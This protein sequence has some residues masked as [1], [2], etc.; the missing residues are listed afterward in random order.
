[1]HPLIPFL[2]LGLT[3]TPALAKTPSV[4]VLGDS[5]SAGYGLKR[6]QAYPALLSEKA[7]GMGSNLIVMNAGVSGDTT[8]GGLRRLPRLLQH[9][10]DVLVIELGINDAFRGVPIPQIEANLQSII[11]LSKKRY[12]QVRI[13][14][15]GMQLPISGDDDYLDRFGAIFPKLAARNHAALIPF[16]LAGVAGNRALNQNDMIHPNAS[17][18]KILAANVWPVLEQVL[19]PSS[20]SGKAG[21]QP[22]ESQ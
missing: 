3:V 13:V 11:D 5:L 22:A 19:Q 1:M 7:K 21:F 9:H 20:V 14:I 4:L 18:Q 8:S 16:L 12:P 6:S 10:I 2:C 17:G 15:A